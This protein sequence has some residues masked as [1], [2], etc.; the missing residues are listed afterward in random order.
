MGDGKEAAFASITEGKGFKTHSLI[1]PENPFIRQATGT[2][3]SV[4]TVEV[5]D[6]LISGVEAAKR[7]KARLGYV[8]DGFIGRMQAE[9]NNAVPS[10]LIDDLA[11]EYTERAQERIG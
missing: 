11:A 5:H 6:I 9:F 10:S 8:P 4:S 3:I 2:Q 1:K 7:V